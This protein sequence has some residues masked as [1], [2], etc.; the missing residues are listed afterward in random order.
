[1]SMVLEEGTPDPHPNPL[2]TQPSASLMHL[3]SDFFSC[4]KRD[5]YPL[6]LCAGFTLS[7][8]SGSCFGVLHLG[9]VLSVVHLCCEL[10]IYL[11]F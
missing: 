11:K 7:G 10:N 8:L 2:V 4:C 9:T 3:K 6:P 5:F 1:M